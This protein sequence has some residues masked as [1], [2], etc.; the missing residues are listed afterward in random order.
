MRYYFSHIYQKSINMPHLITIIWW[1][2]RPDGSVKMRIRKVV[3]PVEDFTMTQT[4]IPPA[5]AAAAAAAAAGNND[6]GPPD[7]LLFSFLYNGTISPSFSCRSASTTVSSGQR[8]GAV[9]G[10]VHDSIDVVHT[11]IVRSI[12]LYILVSIVYCCSD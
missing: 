5:G 8:G 2:H 6:A 12:L 1:E 4:V 11:L 10:G 9:G 7:G 3:V